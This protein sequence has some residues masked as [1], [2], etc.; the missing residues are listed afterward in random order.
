MKA[1]LETASRVARMWKV[2]V[3]SAKCRASPPPLSFQSLNEPFR[4]FRGRGRGAPFEIP[5][6]QASP[7]K[8]L[9][10]S[11]D[12]LAHFRRVEPLRKQA[13]SHQQ[14][15]GDKRIRP[16]SCPGS[17]VESS[18]T[19]TAAACCR[20]RE[21]SLLAVER[22]KT[23]FR[24]GAPA[25][26]QAERLSHGRE[27][28]AAAGLP[29][30]SGSRLPQSMVGGCDATTSLRASP[31]TRRAPSAIGHRGSYVSRGWG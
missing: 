25:F 5:R 1:G 29:R 30:K 27:T 28:A 7:G 6:A 22:S 13:E 15:N 14:K 19:W 16:F 31:A 10:P 4:P 3:G 23:M 24:W 12:L 8:P 26:A 2:Y 9:A 20:F 11:S 18:V 21:A 17:S